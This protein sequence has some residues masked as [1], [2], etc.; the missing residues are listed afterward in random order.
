MGELQPEATQQGATHTYSD[1]DE[2]LGRGP[3]GE[4]P[5]RLLRRTTPP[6]LWLLFLS[7]GERTDVRNVGATLVLRSLLDSHG[8]WHRAEMA[9]C[10]GNLILH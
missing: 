7:I 6:P 2:R 10:I 4:A 3:S 5:P 9:F 1:G 8:A